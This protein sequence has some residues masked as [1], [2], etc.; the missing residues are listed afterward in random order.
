MN[1]FAV[2]SFV[3][4]WKVFAMQNSPDVRLNVGH[5]ILAQRARIN[6]PRFSLYQKIQ[7]F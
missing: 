5:A 6:F 4:F 2:S 7:V 3:M 1:A